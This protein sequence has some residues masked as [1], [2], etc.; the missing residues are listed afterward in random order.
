MPVPGAEINIITGRPLIESQEDAASQIE[1]QEEDRLLK[2]A[3]YAKIL[4]GPMGEKI[5]DI[6]RDSLE[7]RICEL[8][9]A[10]PHAQAYVR[11]LGD[12][13]VREAIGKQSAEALMNRYLKRRTDK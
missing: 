8:V 11:L 9:Q 4:D 2:Q 1:A 6:I 3:Q 13:S 5:L 10:D 7:Q 12:L